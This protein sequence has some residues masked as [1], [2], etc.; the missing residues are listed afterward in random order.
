MSKSR[1]TDEEMDID[2]SQLSLSERSRLEKRSKSKK[3]YIVC[4]IIGFCIGAGAIFAIGHPF[5]S[6]SYQ[7][8]D[9]KALEKENDKLSKENQSLTQKQE[10]DEKKLDEYEDIINKAGKSLYA[11]NNLIKSAYEYYE[12]NDK[13]KA[14]KLLK[15]LTKSNYD[16]SEGKQLFVSLGGKN[17]EKTKGRR[18]N[19]LFVKGRQQYN[20][21][22]YDKA[23][24][25]LLE[26]DSLD[27]NDQS[28]LYFIGRC[29]DK[30]NDADQAIY[31]YEK[32]IQLGDSSARGI[33]AL[34]RLNELS[35]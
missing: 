1:N 23:L 21:E 10:K 11:R 9:Y 25:K 14:K 26:A 24:K 13:K 6:E 22:N 33:L 29:Y 18:A 32:V 2:I 8:S 17:E 4:L 20:W 16:F 34:E 15:D 28:I 3:M 7:V 5:E 19:E 30:K 27:G 31:Y 12:N 35:E